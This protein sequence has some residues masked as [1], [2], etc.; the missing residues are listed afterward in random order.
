MRYG[1]PQLLNFWFELLVCYL[2]FKDQVDLDYV[3]SLDI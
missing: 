2:K 3:V 1:I